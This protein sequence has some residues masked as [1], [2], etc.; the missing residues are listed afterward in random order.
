MNHMKAKTSLLPLFEKAL[1]MSFQNIWR[2][3]VLTLATIFVIGIIV[4]TFNI[5]LA[6]NFITQDAVT[7]LNQKV[8]LIVY[9]KETTDYDQ[10]LKIIKDIEAQEGVIEANY[11]SKEDALKELKQ[12]HPDLSLAFEKYQLGNPLPASLNIVTAHPEYHNQ[13]SKFLQQEK[14]SIFLS[15]IITNDE[16]GSPI[17]S[18]VSQNLLRVTDFA[19]QIIIWLIVTFVLGGTLIILNALHITIFSRK[20][21][22]EVMK[23]VGASTWF[24]RLPFIIESIIYTVLAVIASFIMISLLSGNAQNEGLS[25]FQSLNKQNISSLLMIEI[26]AAI[27]LSTLSSFI[28]VHQY[29]QKKVL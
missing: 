19:K 12:L 7:Q 5:I 24:I 25:I 9:V 6:I 13:L 23:L 16:Q 29:L 17:I 2:N 14:Y 28:A 22:I 4:F 21:E 26:I 10:T 8:D 20:K 1:K 3:K 27:I 11:T 18:S 15:T